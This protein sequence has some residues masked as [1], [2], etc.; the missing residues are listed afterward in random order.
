MLNDSV[1]VIEAE[2]PGSLLTDT[3]ICLGDKVHLTAP[4]PGVFEWSTGATTSGI[5]VLDAGS[6]TLTIANECGNFIYE[7]NIE[8]EL[9]DCPIYIPNVFSPNGDGR[10]D[11]FL[12]F[13]SCDFPLHNDGFQIFDRWGSLVYTSNAD[14]LENIRWDGA[15][16]GM[17]AS[18]GVYTWV[19]E[20]TITP[21]NRP[22]HKVLRG[23]VT[24]LR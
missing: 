16:Y 17:P 2:K 18:T 9:C 8:T 7:S 20:Y 19:L 24:I 13:A 21:K 15:V 10:N 22:E 1:V 4:L 14:D 11:E 3:L 6:Y 12:V 5:D 23:D